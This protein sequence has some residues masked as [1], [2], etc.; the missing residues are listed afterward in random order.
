VENKMLSVHA[1]VKE[2]KHM[3][4][5]LKVGGFFAVLGLLVLGALLVPAVSAGQFA[6]TVGSDLPAL[7]SGQQN[8]TVVEFIIKDEKDSTMFLWL[9][10]EQSPQPIKD[11]CTNLDKDLNDLKS[12]DRTVKSVIV[13]AVSKENRV[14]YG[15]NLAT[16]LFEK[17]ETPDYSV[18]KLIEEQADAGSSKTIFMPLTDLP[19][20]D[21]A[22]YTPPQE[23]NEYYSWANSTSNPSGTYYAFM[24]AT[25][26]VQKY[27][28]YWHT[29]SNYVVSSNDANDVTHMFADATATYSAGD[30]RVY[31]DFH[32]TYYSGGQYTNNGVN[33]GTF[34]VS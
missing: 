19:P 4:P 15:L 11:L 28:S 34:T 16:G 1:L 5:K 33:G 23:G 3:K 25:T 6:G 14:S 13:T 8:L 12:Q 31:G 2:V 24:S 29:W 18:D 26:R 20:T 32:G 21:T 22:G 30:Y 9:D 27:N 7:L 17:L 10:A